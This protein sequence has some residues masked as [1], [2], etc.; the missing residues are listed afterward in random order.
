M[1]VLAPGPV[2]FEHSSDLG[3][4]QVIIETDG[5]YRWRVSQAFEGNG[6]NVKIEAGSSG[7][8]MYLHPVNSSNVT[9]VQYSLCK[10]GWWEGRILE[11]ERALRDAK[12]FMDALKCS[13]YIAS[14]KLTDVLNK[15]DK[16][17]SDES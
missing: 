8:Q 9:L 3:S 7:Q 15:E 10:P 2:K 5:G 12:E 11:L 13:E 1:K 4:R 6:L 17:D 16:A 14:K